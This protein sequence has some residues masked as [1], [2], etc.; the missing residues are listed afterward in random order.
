MNVGE[1]GLSLNVNVNYTLTGF[2]TLTLDITRPSGSAISRTGAD[3]TAPA[4]ALVTPDMGTFAASQYAKYI[5]KT[6]DLTEAGEYT[7]RLTYTD[8]SKRLISDSTSFT[9][10]A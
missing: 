1:Y 9:V 6:G 2:T 8:A 10:N 7:V 5:I 4:V 3:V